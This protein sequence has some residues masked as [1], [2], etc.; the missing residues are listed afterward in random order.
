MVKDDP[1]K[2]WKALAG[3]VAAALSYAV[4]NG[5][6]GFSDL[7]SSI[8]SSVVAGLVVFATP[9]PKRENG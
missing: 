9:N 1:L 5:L 4:S 3:S 2:P 7:W 6:F 8:A